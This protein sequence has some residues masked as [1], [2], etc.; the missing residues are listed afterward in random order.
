MK[1]LLVLALSIFTL[2]AYADCKVDIELADGSKVSENVCLIKNGGAEGSEYKAKFDSCNCKDKQVTEIEGNATT[3]KHCDT[4][5]VTPNYE[6]VS[7]G[8][9]TGSVKA[10][11]Q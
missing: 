1:I 7:N 3:V 10:I 9:G 2:G 5:R 11:T 8:D 6:Y 4:D